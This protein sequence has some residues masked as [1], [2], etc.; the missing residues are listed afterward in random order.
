[1]ARK[2]KKAPS[3]NDWF[4]WQVRQLRLEGP[5]LYWSQR[6]LSSISRELGRN[7]DLGE[8]VR[9]EVYCGNDCYAGKYSKA[10]LTDGTTVNFTF[11]I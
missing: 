6:C 5:E 4:D 10:T 8:I 9:L 3:L 1:M 11:L 2:K 7:V